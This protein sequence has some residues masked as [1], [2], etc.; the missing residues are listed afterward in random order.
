MAM[1]AI[2]A[3]Q[4]VAPAVVACVSLMASAMS[5]ATHAMVLVMLVVV[6]WAATFG[7]AIGDR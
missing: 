4:A 7:R 1:M 5:G 3:R 2:P 6:G